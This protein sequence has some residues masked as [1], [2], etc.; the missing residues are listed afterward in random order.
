MPK[1][2]PDKDEGRDV[3]E[4]ALDFAPAVAALISGNAARRS[5]LKKFRPLRGKQAGFNHA[6]N[7][8]TLG[9][10]SLG[11]AAGLIPMLAF[12]GSK[13]RKKD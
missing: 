13:H 5:F 2:E 9:G 11:G 7:M 3:F 6:K 8:T 4:T 10:A 12:S 1:H